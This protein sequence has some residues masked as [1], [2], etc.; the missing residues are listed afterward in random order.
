[1]FLRWYWAVAGCACEG[2]V[3]HEQ[4]TTA[5]SERHPDMAAWPDD[6]HLAVGRSG[7]TVAADESRDALLAAVGPPTPPT[8]FGAPPAGAPLPPRAPLPPPSGQPLPPPLRPGTMPPPNPYA[9]APPTPAVGGQPAPGWTPPPKP[10]LIPLRP[11]TLGTLLGASFQVMRR[12]P[13]P[14]FGF[15]LLLAGIV[16]VVSVLGLAIAGAALFSRPFQGGTTDDQLTLIAG[17]IFGGL[18]LGLLVPGALSLIAFSILQGIISLEVARGTVGEKLKLGG[19][20]RA[21]KGR[22]AVLVGWSVLVIAAVAAF[23]VVVILVITA[24]TSGS[25]A[26]WTRTT[27]VA[28]SAS[29]SRSRCC[30]T[31]RSSCSPPGSAPRRRSCRAS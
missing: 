30:P 19:L 15:A 11:L 23:F 13:R 17:G 18:V 14:T 22:I 24:A 29:S 10:G 8:P 5:I 25:R 9:Y 7:G 6:R 21:A 12:N 20:W 1:M 4:S 2:V 27:S 26:R 3:L 28:R 31:S 16:S